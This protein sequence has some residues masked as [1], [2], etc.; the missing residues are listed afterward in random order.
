MKIILIAVAVAV[1]AS[2]GSARR[3]EPI[4]GKLPV[5][6]GQYREGRQVFMIHCQ[7]CHP[8]GEGGLGPALNNKPLPGPLIRFQV[9]HGLGAMPAFPPG[10]ISDDQ[11]HQLTDY[12]RALRQH[13]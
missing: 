11:L 1:L 10:K 5:G 4:T 13:R 12:L 3:S 7:P 9:R 6:L 2:C 8:N